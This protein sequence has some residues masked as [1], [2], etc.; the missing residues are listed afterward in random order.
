MAGS[1]KNEFRQPAIDRRC[2]RRTSPLQSGTRAACSSSPNV[3]VTPAG[4]SS[5]GV[6]SPPCRDTADALAPRR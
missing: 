2:V 4:A 5:A 3:N 6:T 1:R